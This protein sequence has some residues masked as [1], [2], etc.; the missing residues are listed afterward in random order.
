VTADGASD[1]P[2]DEVIAA[3]DAVVQERESSS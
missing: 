1:V 3:V 2:E